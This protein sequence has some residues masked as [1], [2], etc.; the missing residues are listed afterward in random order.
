VFYKPS[1]ILAVSTFFLVSAAAAQTTPSFPDMPLDNA[2]L[3][4]Q[5]QAE[6]VYERTDYKR[7]FFIYRNEL[8]PIGDKYGQYMVGFMY[9]TG[10]GVAE[11]RVMASAWYRLAAERGTKEFMRARDQVMKTLSDE[12]RAESDEIFIALRKEFGDL[13][14]LTRAIRED[15]ETLRKRTGSRVG[16]DTSPVTI[17]DMNEANGVH[18]A[19]VDYARIE[20]Q[21]KSRLAYIARHAEI[22]IIDLDSEDVASADIDAIERKVAAALSQLP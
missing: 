8:V 20:R 15:Y 3:A 10:K 4:V 2:T 13:A 12:Q 14:L 21:M 17:I 22:G 11:D 6:E 16:G 1:A 19:S 7:A 18:S 9:L 5:N